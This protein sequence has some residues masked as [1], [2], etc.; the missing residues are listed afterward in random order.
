MARKLVESTKSG[1]IL[2]HV[3]TSI[4]ECAS[5]DVKGLYHSAGY[6]HPEVTNAS[7]AYYLQEILSGVTRD[8]TG[9]SHPFEMP[10]A[11]DVSIFTDWLSVNE[12]VDIVLAEI[13]RQN[14]IDSRYSMKYLD[15]PAKDAE[16]NVTPSSYAIEARL[17]NDAIA[18]MLAMKNY[19]EEYL[20]SALQ[21]LQLYTSVQGIRELEKDEK[22]LP[23]S[24]WPDLHRT[25]PIANIPSH[26]LV[27]PNI[28]S[29]LVHPYALPLLFPKAFKPKQPKISP[30]DLSLYPLGDR[31]SMKCMLQTHIFPKK[32]Y[33]TYVYALIGIDDPRGPLPAPYNQL[34]HEHYT[35]LRD[36]TLPYMPV[37]AW[38]SLPFERVVDGKSELVLTRAGLPSI[39]S[40]TARSILYAH[41]EKDKG[42]S[43]ASHRPALLNNAAGIT[44]KKIHLVLSPLSS[45]LDEVVAIVNKMYH[46]HPVLVANDERIY[47]SEIEALLLES[48]LSKGTIVNQYKQPF[49]DLTAFS[50]LDLSSYES[51]NFDSMEYSVPLFANKS[52]QLHEI[53]AL[54]T[55]GVLSLH[56]HL[57]NNPGALISAAWDLWTGL[58][59][60]HALSLSDDDYNWREHQEAEDNKSSIVSSSQLVVFSSRLIVHVENMLMFD[61]CLTVTIVLPSAAEE[62][63]TAKDVVNSITGDRLPP[64][65]NNS[66]TDASPDAKL[67]DNFSYLET[68]FDEYVKAAYNLAQLFPTRVSIENVE[69]DN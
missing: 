8:L 41:A 15:V 26:L 55:S 65:L 53:D 42:N 66:S 52:A 43:E 16:L 27:S 2:V 38:D 36:L 32:L 60:A 29:L 13:A 12:A 30:R 23:A 9:V 59:W 69:L 45:I 62:V 25:A 4:G 31:T 22:V 46:A 11:P 54:F 14:Y 10:V 49:G 1:F 40:S 21:K 63:A 51:G 61:P 50:Q 20:D 5:R 7:T 64:I 6:I 17:P 34:T 68:Y 67:S 44:A 18:L 19:Q 24:N 39:G 37:F 57:R 35:L 3:S 47:Q 58:R 28:H 56:S 33:Q 48:K